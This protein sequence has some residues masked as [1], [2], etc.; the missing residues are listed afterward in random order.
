MD[1]PATEISPDT[2]IEPLVAVASSEPLGRRISEPSVTEDPLSEI[3][4]PSPGMRVGVPAVSASSRAPV[5]ES[6]W[7]TAWA[8]VNAGVAIRSK[9]VVEKEPSAIVATPLE[10]ERLMAL[11]PVAVKLFW[12]KERELAEMS[13]VPADDSG[14]ARLLAELGFDKRM[15]EAFKAMVAPAAI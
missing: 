7:L 14:A 2:V 6:E 15:S 11:M 10:A 5:D 4:A 9:P 13:S 1:D 3:L 8:V 12:P